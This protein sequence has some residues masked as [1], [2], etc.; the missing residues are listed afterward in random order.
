MGEKPAKWRAD[1]LAKLGSSIFAEAAE[2]KAEASAAGL[3]VIDLSIGSPDLPP[4]ESVREAMAAAVK[5]ADAYRYQIGRA[6][7]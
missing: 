6:H 7:V 5:R 1:K 4:S 2:W 3:D